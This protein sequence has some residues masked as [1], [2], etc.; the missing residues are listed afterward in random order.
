MLPPSK[1]QFN[2]ADIWFGGEQTTGVHTR[3][4]RSGSLALATCI[5]ADGLSKGSG[6]TAAVGISDAELDE[7]R[8]MVRLFIQSK[9]RAS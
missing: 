8:R 2:G 7:A 6:T 1:L 5:G 9:T 4:I 3:P